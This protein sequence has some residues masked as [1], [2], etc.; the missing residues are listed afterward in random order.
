MHWKSQTASSDI[1]NNR[2][3]RKKPLLLVICA[4]PYLVVG[5]DGIKLD[6]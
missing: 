2:L 6:K 1:Q 4:N 3:K 5:I